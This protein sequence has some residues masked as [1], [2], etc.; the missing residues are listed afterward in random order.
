M[1]L[2]LIA[3]SDVS[4]VCSDSVLGGGPGV[5]RRPEL[6]LGEEVLWSGLSGQRQPTEVLLHPSV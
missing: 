4:C 1:Y 2:S 3:L 5:R 6:Q